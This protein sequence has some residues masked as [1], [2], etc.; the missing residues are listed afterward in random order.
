MTSR[1]TT[2]RTIR[3]A[4]ATAAALM[5]MSQAAQAKPLVPVGAQVQATQ[6]SSAYQGTYRPATTVSPQPPDRTDLIGTTRAVPRP[7]G[8]ADGGRD[9][10]GRTD[11]RK[12]LRLDR[13]HGGRRLDARRRPDRRSRTGGARTPPRPALGLTAPAHDR[14][15]SP[16]EPARSAA[17]AALGSVCFRHA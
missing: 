1:T 9:D 2:T 6:S 10:S 13:G 3:L 17:C 14:A 8:P 5:L 7:A 4:I 12:R 11:E 15:G 16:H